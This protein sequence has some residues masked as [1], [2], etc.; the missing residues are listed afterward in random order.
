MSNLF[1]GTAIEEWRREPIRPLG[2]LS[3]FV[4]NYLP[5]LVSAAETDVGVRNDVLLTVIGVLEELD[6]ETVT[7]LLHKS[8]LD[9]NLSLACFDLKILETSLLYLKFDPLEKLTKLV[10]QFSKAA[11]QPFFITYEELV[12]IN[13]NTDPRTFTPGFI[14]ESEF[15]F[16][17]GHFQIEQILNKVI[18]WI[19]KAA[20]NL[21]IGDIEAAAMNI[22]QASGAFAK[23]LDYGKQVGFKMPRE[24]FQ[25]FRK[26]FIPSPLRAGVL[27]GPSG[28]LTAGIP[29]VEFLLSGE[30]L[31]S[32]LFTFAEK[33]L[34]YF[35]RKGRVEIVLAFQAADEGYTI[36][37]LAEKLGNPP[38]LIAAIE[39]LSAAIR[40]FRAEHYKSVQHQLPELIKGNELGTAGVYDPAQFLRDRMKIRHVKR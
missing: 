8:S 19:K 25:Y 9:P 21:M 11:Q 3:T 24:H 33:H 36:T 15:S 32:E 16:Y 26:F 13:P 38:R 39:D 18:D 28:L 34:E 40:H 23:I 31:P 20:T 29:V 4:V 12:L 30:N 2:E 7:K 5:T 6:D 35:P 10:E 27:V 37:S 17:Q 1:S 22:L 14:G